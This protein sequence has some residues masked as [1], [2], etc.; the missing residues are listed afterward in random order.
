MFVSLL[1]FF[2]IASVVIGPVS[3]LEGWTY[4]DTDSTCAGTNS[5]PC[6]PVS[7]IK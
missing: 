1:S 4:V 2:A 6:G 7:K 3:A 5:D